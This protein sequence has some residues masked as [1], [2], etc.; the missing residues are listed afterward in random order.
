MQCSALYCQDAFINTLLFTVK[1]ER[2]A[3]SGVARTFP[4]GQVS[5]GLKEK[6]NEENLRKNKKKWNETLRKVEL[7]PTWDCKAGYAMGCNARCV[8]ETIASA[9]WI[10]SILQSW[11]WYCRNVNGKW[12]LASK[13]LYQLFDFISK[14]VSPCLAILVNQRDKRWNVA[15]QNS[16]KNWSFLYV[17][18][19]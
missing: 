4:G 13:R 17:S 16:N 19:V 14:V 8:N 9:Q 6:E 10:Y 15:C 1:I 12:I 11:Q 7:L 2:Y 18:V 5:R 3:T